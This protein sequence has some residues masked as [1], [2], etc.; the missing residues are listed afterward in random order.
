[1]RIIAD[2][3]RAG[4]PRGRFGALE[5]ARRLGRRRPPSLLYINTATVTT[6]QTFSHTTV[7]RGLNPSESFMEVVLEALNDSFVEQ[8]DGMR[9]VFECIELSGPR[10]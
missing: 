10:Q 4:R 7:P 5:L 3:A 6:D 1:M 9:M 8:V 2:S